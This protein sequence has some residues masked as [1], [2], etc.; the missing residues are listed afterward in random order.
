MGWR[1]RYCPSPVFIA[2]FVALCV[3]YQCLSLFWKSIPWTKEWDIRRSLDLLEVA[4]QN[5]ECLYTWNNL[6][7]KIKDYEDRLKKK[8][9]SNTKKILLLYFYHSTGIE[10]SLLYKRVLTKLGYTI[11]HFA[12]IDSIKVFI[13]HNQKTLGRDA[14]MYIP[15]NESME[16]S[17]KQKQELVELV[18]LTKVKVLTQMQQIPCIKDEICQLA[19]HF[20]ELQNLSVCTYHPEESRN[21]KLT[22]VLSDNGKKKHQYL[23]TRGLNQ[24]S[25]SPYQN[26]RV[27]HHDH[28]FQDFPVIRTFVVITSLSPLR[29]F[30]HST[31]MVQT[32][33]KKRFTPI[34]L[35]KFYQDFFKSESPL[36]AFNTLK[37]II[38]KLLLTME[39]ASEAVATGHNSLNRCRESFQLVTFDIGYNSASHPIV[40]QVKEQF[41]LNDLNMDGYTTM[42]TILED[43]FNVILH[44]HSYGILEAM[45]EVQNCLSLKNTCWMDSIL[46][47]TWEQM[48]NLCFLQQEQTKLGMFVMLYPSN[49]VLLK[50]LRHDLY[51][52]ADLRDNLG[53]TLAVHDLLSDL[54][55]CLQ[56]LQEINQT[57]RQKFQDKKEN[58]LSVVSRQNERVS[59]TKKWMKCSDD[60][61]TLSYINRIFS[62]PPLDLT[63]EFNPKIKDYY[64]ELPFDVVTVEI[65]AEP[66]NC[67]S[68]VHL[69]NKNGPRIAKYPLGLGTN[70]ITLYVTDESL[71]TP[72]ILRSYRIT[73]Y[74]EDRPSL[75]LFD[76]YKMCGFLQMQ[77]S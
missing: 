34:Q 70:E 17:C 55:E 6:V 51:H 38:S 68:Q 73:I 46:A 35:Q 69:D 49:S 13:T 32:E 72:V 29:A 61:D 52:K 23:T 39:V 1:R 57:S 22:S 62:N 64:A 24:L 58:K 4:T 21:E 31:A 2:L 53:S 63:P 30:I 40:L 28:P 25:K 12:E 71:K 19:A 56:S 65:G 8:P 37:E 3:F 27:Y 48:D 77:R 42:E 33:P 11:H 36:Q 26:V 14:L 44:N 66:A 75:P 74:R 50:A 16:I 76:H 67:K 9:F 60:N 54:Y 41:L 18:Q 15:F 20:P 47:F 43:V 10:E 7:T 59:V 5:K 45:E